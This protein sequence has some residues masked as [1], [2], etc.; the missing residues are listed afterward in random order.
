MS[1][2]EVAAVTKFAR[3]PPRDR[4]LPARPLHRRA[5]RCA[6]SPRSTQL[7]GISRPPVR[8]HRRPRRARARVALRRGR[9]SPPSR[10]SR[11]T[12]ASPMQTSSARPRSSSCTAA[13]ARTVYLNTR[14]GSYVRDAD[15]AARRGARSCATALRGRCSSPADVRAALRGD[16]G[17]RGRDPIAVHARKDGDDVLIGVELAATTGARPIDWSRPDR[18]RPAPRPGHASRHLPGDRPPPRRPTSGSG[19]AIEVEV[20]AAEP[21]L[22]RLRP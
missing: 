12:G 15:R 11:P 6:R 19:T 21:A 2:A 17:R 5:S 13:P 10:G 8:G 3:E 20:S 1:D 4:G 16:R 18:D 7:F 14:I 9:S 22:F